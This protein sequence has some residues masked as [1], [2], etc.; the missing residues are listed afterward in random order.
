[1]TGKGPAIRYRVYRGK[2]ICVF[3]RITLRSLLY[4]YCPPGYLYLS[5]EYSILLPECYLVFSCHFPG[6]FP[7]SPW[8]DSFIVAVAISI[9]KRENKKYKEGI[10][11]GASH[12]HNDKKR[13]QAL[14]DRVKKSLIHQGKHFV[15]G[16]PSL[17]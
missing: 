16:Q 14:S 13:T 5:P 8:G 7:L 17:S 4:F 3:I 10:I 12:P 2:G 6:R 15:M 1:M 9:F 11:M